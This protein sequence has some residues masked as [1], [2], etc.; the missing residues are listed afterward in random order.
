MYLEQLKSSIFQVVVEK[1]RNK[2][3]AY[4]SVLQMFPSSGDVVLISPT[5]QK[6]GAVPF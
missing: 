3:L 2:D 6:N 4:L 1:A 5:M